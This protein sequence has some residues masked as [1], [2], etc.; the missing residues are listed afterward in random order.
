MGDFAPMNCPYCNA[1]PYSGITLGERT[2]DPDARSRW[3]DCESFLHFNSDMEW[4]ITEKCADRAKVYNREQ[5]E[6]AA[7]ERIAAAITDERSFYDEGGEGWNILTDALKRIED[8]D[9]K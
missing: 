2:D 7:T 6:R 4:T 9:A 1:G 8:S 5:G 3:Y